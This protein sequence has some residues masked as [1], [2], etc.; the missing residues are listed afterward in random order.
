MNETCGGLVNITDGLP[1][2]VSPWPNGTTDTTDIDCNVTVTSLVIAYR[3]S[4]EY[5]F[6]K[7]HILTL[8]I[9]CQSGI[10]VET[11]CIENH[12][13]AIVC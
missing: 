1:M 8:K 10:T 6:E 12:V 2:L 3:F 4:R 9:A 13:S 5:H 11:F 7:K